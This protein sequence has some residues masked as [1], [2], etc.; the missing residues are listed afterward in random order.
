M[1]KQRQICN[2]SSSGMW[3]TETAA[4]MGHSLLC[5][6]EQLPLSAEGIQIARHKVLHSISHK[7]LQ[8][9]FKLLNVLF[10]TYLAVDTINPWYTVDCSSMKMGSSACS[11]GHRAQWL[12]HSHPHPFQAPLIIKK[13]IKKHHISERNHQ[14]L[15]GKVN[16]QREKKVCKWVGQEKRMFVAQIK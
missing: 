7:E 8:K 12:M 3:I 14:P 4:G 15:K 2:T 9:A 11:A 1:A 16:N 10:P 5:P 13:R 6:C